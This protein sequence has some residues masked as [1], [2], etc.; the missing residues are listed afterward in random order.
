MTLAGPRITVITPPFLISGSPEGPALVFTQRPGAEAHLLQQLLD[1]N[2]HDLKRCRRD[3]PTPVREDQGS[4]LPQ[5]SDLGACKHLC[6][7]P[8]DPCCSCFLWTTGG[9]AGTEALAA[10]RMRGGNGRDKEIQRFLPPALRHSHHVVSSTRLRP[11]CIL[12]MAAISHLHGS[13]R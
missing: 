8:P 3:E 11:S 4:D 9:A 13:I 6:A 1:Q 12:F 7:G 5:T 2:L 10:Q